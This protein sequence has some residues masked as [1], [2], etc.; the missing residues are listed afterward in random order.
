M[1]LP[2][3]MVRDLGLAGYL[4]FA[5]PNVIGAAAMGWVLRSPGSSLRLTTE[6]ATACR[7][8]SIITNGYHAF[9]ASW[10]L[11]FAAMQ[12][13]VPGW[14]W[15]LLLA[16]GAWAGIA[17]LLVS[18]DGSSRLAAL[19]TLGISL[20]ALLLWLSRTGDVSPTLAETLDARPFSQ[21][22]LWML[23]VSTLGFLLC[24]YL[25]LTFHRARQGCDTPAQSKVAFG[26]G[27]GV[28]F[29]LMI[30]FTLL[31]AGPLVGIVDADQNA[32]MSIPVLLAA[33]LGIHVAMQFGF[34]VSAHGRE[35]NRSGDTAKRWHSVVIWAS[36]GLGIALAGLSEQRWLDMAPG[37]IGYR[38]FLSFY[39]LVFPAYMWLNVID[40]R[41]RAMRSATARSLA[42]TLIAMVLASPFYFIG[43]M[44]REEPWLVPGVAIILLAKLAAGAAPATN[45]ERSG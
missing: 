27:F 37:E 30:A 26:V 16:A 29:A 2:I 13:E 42:V 28:C 12:M 39:G 1:Y 33:A 40:V 32:G 4:V 31:Y 20:T 19:A 23:P 34:T 8:F 10:L 38:V 36:V 14:A 24:P 6:H 45:R 15:S 41:R 7:G 44:M 25:D 5:V 35:V 21:D 22:A 18:R 43:F 9:W 17:R 11:A 3:L